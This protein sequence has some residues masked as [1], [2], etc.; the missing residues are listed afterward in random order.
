[1]K[2]VYFTSLGHDTRD[3]CLFWIKEALA[4][5]L[6]TIEEPLLTELKVAVQPPIRAERVM[7]R[8]LD[9]CS[10]YVRW[11]QRKGEAKDRQ[12]RR[13]E[14]SPSWMRLLQ[15]CPRSAGPL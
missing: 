6:M 14:C 9:K 7:K 1:M 13:R 10:M 4:K 8:F 11:K 3:S 12:R 2:E 15:L 5:P